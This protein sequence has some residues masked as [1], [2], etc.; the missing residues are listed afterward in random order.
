MR[1]DD[2]LSEQPAVPRGDDRLSDRPAPQ[3]AGPGAFADIDVSLPPVTIR[4]VAFVF[5]VYA[6]WPFVTMQLLTA[7]GF[8]PGPTAAPPTAEQTLTLE[9]VSL[10][11]N[12]LAFP[13]QLASLGLLPRLTGVRPWQIGLTFRRLGW[14]CLGGATGWLVLTPACF[15]ANYALVSLYGPEAAGNVKE[16]PFVQMA[17]Q[18]LTPAEWF[19]LVF[20]ATVSAPAMEELLFRGA[21]LSWLER[22]PWA[23]HIAM[24]LAF[25]LSLP[26]KGNEAAVWR[27]GGWP[28][29]LHL[30]PVL[31]VL[32]L[33]VVYL[34]VCQLSRGP[35]VPAI[36][37]ASG[38]FAAVHSFAW[39]SPVALFVLAL[40]LGWLAYR[41]RS[42][43]G[44]VVLHGLFNAVSCA[45]LFWQ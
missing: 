3:P 35:T 5:F 29:A 15:A 2:R 44:P 10:L 41:T 11:A 25:V 37:A 7:A 24:M 26:M 38:L 28:L 16:H 45:L 12:G 20:T 6:F 4:V 1:N 42:L 8:G 31:F 21:L 17:Q 43:A 30:A 36:F 22:R 19:L 27:Q 14:N 13:L 34:A 9:R 33:I 23:S 18:G 39:P 40:G 32:T